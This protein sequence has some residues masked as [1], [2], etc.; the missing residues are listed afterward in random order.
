MIALLSLL[1]LVSLSMSHSTAS[2]YLIELNHEAYLQ[3]VV[4]NHTNT[5]RNGPWFIMF[6]APWCG[7]CKKLMPTWNELADIENAP[8]KNYMKVAVV[9]CDN[10]DNN[11]LCGAFDIT[12]Y[13][14]ML[15]LKGEKYYRYRGERTLEKITEFMY[16]GGY[17]E[18]EAKDIPFYIEKTEKS[19]SAG[20]IGNIKKLSQTIL[21]RLGLIRLPKEV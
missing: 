4:N 9:D 11:D 14:R 6:F 1:S 16:E 15:Y 10:Q 21:K 20:I 2:K 18:V 12:G 3:H 13:P 5:L 7:H 17:Q 19:V 8:N